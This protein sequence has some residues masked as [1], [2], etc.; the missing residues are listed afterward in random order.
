MYY[1][2]VYNIIY[3]MY[4]CVHVCM[5][6]CTYIYI[7][8]KNYISQLYIGKI[9]NKKFFVATSFAYCFSSHKSFTTILCKLNVLQV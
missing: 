5:S 3:K 4:V 6:G 2:Y 7:Y 8:W 9:E 1:I